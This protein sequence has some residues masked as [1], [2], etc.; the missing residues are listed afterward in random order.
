[1]PQAVALAAIDTCGHLTERQHRATALFGPAAACIAGLQG[2]AHGLVAEQAI[3]KGQL[4]TLEHIS[5][6]LNEDAA[7]HLVRHAIGTA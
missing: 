3:V 2:F 6:R 4:F 1:M 7:I 5:A